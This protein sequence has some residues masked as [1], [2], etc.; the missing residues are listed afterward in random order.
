M[1][2][3]L[4]KII[5]FCF[6]VV[7]LFL[8]P[9]T[10][11]ALEITYPNIPGIAQ[12][13]DVPTMA[14]Y[15]Y[16]LSLIVGVMICTLSLIFAGISWLLSRGNPGKLVF[17]KGQINAA[18]LGLAILLLS[19]VF[20][21]VINPNLVII[22]LPGITSPVIVPPEPMPSP[23]IVKNKFWELPFGFLEKDVLD[24]A[25]AVTS[26][27]NYP[28]LVQQA[29]QT[30]EDRARELQV[31]VNQCRCSNLR[32]NCD[33]NC[34][35]L[36]CTATT[37]GEASQL[38]LCPNWTAIQ[39]KINE[40]QTARD[41]VKAKRQALLVAQVN[42]QIAEA[43]LIAAKGLLTSCPGPLDLKSFL[44][45]QD[46]P[47]VEKKIFFTDIMD[48][49]SSLVCSSS[50]SPIYLPSASGSCKLSNTGSTFRSIPKL[51]DL[52]SFVAIVEGAAETF[53]VPPSLLLGVMYGEGAF[54]PGRYDWTNENVEN[55]SCEGGGMPNCNPTSFPS[56]GI[57]PFYGDMWDNLKDAVNTVAPGRVSNPC[58]LTD[59]TFA[60]AKDLS[61]GTLG[62][63][64][65]VGTSCF[66]ISLN[67][68]HSVHTS[69][70][71]WEQSDI[72]TAIKVWENGYIVDQ[73]YTAV[74][75]GTAGG[76]AAR[77]KDISGLNNDD[78]CEHYQDCFG[79]GGGCS[80]H[81]YYL[82][83]VT[84]HYK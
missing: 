28:D 80:S 1:P 37:G 40:I 24:K 53:H 48:G 27:I 59:A 45:I 12:P 15:L 75:G 62:Y 11:L 39:N 17:A 63:S 68:G 35:A 29:V 34:S 20:L 13:T 71:S 3:L 38:D 82:W 83:D 10:S 56:T 61:H 21:K 43:R 77:C 25:L 14:I 52:P 4:P 70:C 41:N 73:C 84:N 8:K 22:N 66:G 60:L 46:W 44:G 51:S 19:F 64:N 55:W 6:F 47:N 74:G 26:P 2:K 30:L 81:T 58:N 72:E 7:A 49:S 57:V 76:D 23:T 31:L 50:P 5:L 67:A 18:F 42:L 69:D 79:G 16:A 32:P 33:N 9:A 36:D 54:N 65:F 78:H